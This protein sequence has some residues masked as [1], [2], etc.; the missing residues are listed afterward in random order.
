MVVIKA[1][2]FIEDDP[3]GTMRAIADLHGDGEGSYRIVKPLETPAR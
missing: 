3:T 2:Q 1:L